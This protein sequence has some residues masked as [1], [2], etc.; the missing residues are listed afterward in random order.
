M[1]VNVNFTLEQF[2]KIKWGNRGTEVHHSASLLRELSSC[3]HHAELYRGTPLSLTA[4][5]AVV[6]YTSC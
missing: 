2:M 4:Q 1:N 3:T 6:V 5:G